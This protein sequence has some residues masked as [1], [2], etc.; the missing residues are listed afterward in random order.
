MST[1][2]LLV[3]AVLVYAAF[4]T[5]TSRAGGHI[6]A[7]LSSGVL[8][9]VGGL[10]PL[11]LWLVVRTARGAMVPTRPAGL[12]YS[13]LAGL[14]VGLFTILLV[15]IYARGGELSFVFPIIY[16]GAIA[17]TALVGWTALGDTFSW[18]HLASV[19]GIVVGIGL[20]AV[21]AK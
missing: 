11:A 1:T 13:V 10:L 14:A 4:A 16:G 21:P 8:N 15:T 2:L 9:G 3:L 5:L 19:A 17:L 18:L 7:R 20:L 6:D 12:V